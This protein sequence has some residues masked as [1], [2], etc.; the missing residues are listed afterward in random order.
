MGAFRRAVR[1][2]PRQKPRSSGCK[3]AIMIFTGK[4]AAA[5]WS[6]NHA[7]EVIS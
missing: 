2:L 3:L 1:N 4:A 6:I 5:L 7:R